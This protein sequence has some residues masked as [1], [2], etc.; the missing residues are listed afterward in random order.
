LRT[1]ACLI[2]GSTLFL[3]TALASA[4]QLDVTVGGSTLFS[5]KS[6]TSSIAF[7][8]PAERGGVYPSASIQ[9]LSDNHFG[10]NVEGA[11]RY[12]E[13]TYNNYQHFRPVFYDAN[14]VFAPPISPKVT[15]DLMAGVG[16][17]TLIFYSQ[18]GTCYTPSGCHSYVNDNHLLLH[19]GGG[20]RYYFWRD[21][22]L[23]VRP[24]AHYYFIPNNYEFH[25]DNVVRLGATIGYTFGSR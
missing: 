2:C 15:V 23:F 22:N 16:G 20:V 9:Y 7:I 14:V 13:G 1:L 3:F 17:E 8:P 4:Q 10:F 24:E 18:L 12:R 19:F 5:T 25:S 6:P 21:R 11:F